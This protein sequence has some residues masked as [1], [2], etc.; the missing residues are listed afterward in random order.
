MC[1]KKKNDT[2][3]AYA[4]I[5]RTDLLPRVRFSMISRCAALSTRSIVYTAPTSHGMTCPESST[6]RASGRMP[7][8]ADSSHAHTPT[9]LESHRSTARKKRSVM[10]RVGWLRLAEASSPCAA[11]AKYEQLE[12]RRR[13]GPSEAARLPHAAPRQLLRLDAGEDMFGSCA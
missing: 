12:P 3:N 1:V 8:H 5:P 10:V 9:C 6:S 2:R 11:A 4:R 13:G 7:P